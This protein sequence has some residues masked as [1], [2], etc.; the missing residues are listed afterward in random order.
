[1][2]HEI[3]CL[4]AL[5][6][7]SEEVSEEIGGAL[8]FSGVDRG[9]TIFLGGDQGAFLF[10]RTAPDE[11]EVHVMLSH[12]GRGAWGFAAARYAR[13]EMERRG[14]RRL[15]A[16]IDPAMRHLALFTRRAGFRKCGEMPPYDIFEW[17]KLCRQQ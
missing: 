5:N 4:S 2:I 11:Y 1:V 9:N 15:W 14:A 7:L 6:K 8:D 16:R 3:E 10:E 12:A 13:D 17:R